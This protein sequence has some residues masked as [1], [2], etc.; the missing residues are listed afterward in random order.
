MALCACLSQACFFAAALPSFTGD[1]ADALGGRAL[2]EP[3][4]LGPVDLACRLARSP[5]AFSTLCAPV[6]AA[7]RSAIGGDHAPGG[8]ALF[9]ATAFLSRHGLLS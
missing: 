5:A 2:G 7:A 6:F 3:A 9:C 8:G 1:G 4:L